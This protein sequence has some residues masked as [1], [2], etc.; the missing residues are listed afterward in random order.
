[1]VCF[2]VLATFALAVACREPTRTASSTAGPTPGSAWP[3]SPALTLRPH[4]LSLQAPYAATDLAFLR[5]AIGKRSMVQLGESI[6]ITDEFP[7]AR[8]SIVRFLHEEMGFDVIAFEGSAIDAWLAE[9]AIYRSRE[10]PA[11]TARRAQ[12]TAWFALWDTEPMLHVMEYVVASHATDSPLYLASFDL[13]PGNTRPFG[14]DAGAAIEALLDAISAY[15][16]RPATAGSWASAMAPALDCWK[17]D[18]PGP[19]RDVAAR[20][21]D[22]LDRWIVAA[23]PAV[24]TKTSR[25]HASAMARIPAMLRARLEMCAEV[26]A[27]NEKRTRVYQEARDRQ[28]AKLAIALRDE[29]SRA[30]RVILWAHHSHVNHNTLGSNIPS[31]GQRLH[32]AMP[33]ALYTIGLFAGSGTAMAV[34]DGACPPIQPTVLASIAK[35]GAETLLA[36]TATGDFFIDLRALDS[37]DT[38]LAAWFA[39]TMSRLEAAG[40]MPTVLARDF[41]AAVFVREVHAVELQSVPAAARAIMSLK[42]AA[43]GKVN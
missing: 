19:A 7:R 5:Q 20:A 17:S 40:R 6:H 18:P 38:S 24:E 1:M 12:T 32:E 10:P 29:V 9:D 37:T 25:A 30:H 15:A 41:D 26:A 4:A 2:R 14:G 21:I 27:A 11:I 8:L 42:C 33:D 34:E 13:Q 35:L 31:M 23:A 16:P 22:Q 28:N 43:G 39:P 3:A 36:G